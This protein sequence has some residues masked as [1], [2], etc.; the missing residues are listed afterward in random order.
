[1]KAI[2]PHAGNGFQPNPPNGFRLIARFFVSCVSHGLGVG[3]SGLVSP[4]PISFTYPVQHEPRGL[5]RDTKSAGQ[6]TRANPILGVEY[7]PHGRQPLVKPKGRLLEYRASLDRE[8]T[9]TPTAVPSPHLGHVG[10]ALRLAVR[11]YHLA[12]RPLHGLHKFNAA[13]SVR[14]IANRILQSLRELNGC[15]HARN[16][17]WVTT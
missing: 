1:M 8:L 6:L 14:E 11:A 5:L 4:C 17:P 15:F 2:V 12:V 3:S 9:V 13:I 16:L 10:H 7:H